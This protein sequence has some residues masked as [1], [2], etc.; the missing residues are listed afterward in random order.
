MEPLVTKPELQS[1]GRRSQRPRVGRA[2][3]A[4]A[5]DQAERGEA[6]LAH[7]DATGT[8]CRMSCSNTTHTRLNAV[9]AEQT[10]Q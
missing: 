7:K 4:A 10:P 1:P 2:Q 9:S 8:G 3:V 6:G 5:G